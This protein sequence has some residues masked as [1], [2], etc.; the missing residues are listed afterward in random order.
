MPRN[1]EL[2]H[3]TGGERGAIADA[4]FASLPSPQNGSSSASAGHPVVVDA[5][6]GAENRPSL[7]GDEDRRGSLPARP[8]VG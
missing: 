7:A 3:R 2:D 8:P 5:L 4:P 1:H 6:T